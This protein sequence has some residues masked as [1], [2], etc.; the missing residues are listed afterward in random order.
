[1]FRRTADAGSLYC[2][3][4]R[5]INVAFQDGGKPTSSLSGNPPRQ[6]LL[7]CLYGTET[8]SQV[9]SEQGKA[10]PRSLFELRNVSASHPG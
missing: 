7:V 1:M 8:R 10:A 4:T 2:L 5:D 9:V 3:G 6:T